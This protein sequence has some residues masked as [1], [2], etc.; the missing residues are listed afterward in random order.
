MSD[1]LPL[2]V[3]RTHYMGIDLGSTFD[4]SAVIVVEGVRHLVPA[5]PTYEEPN[6]HQVAEDHY[7]VRH[8][9][10]SEMGTHYE[11]TVARVAEVSDIY[12]PRF[13]YFDETGV[14]LAVHSLFRQ[15]YIAGRLRPMP[16]G[17]TI[18]G[19]ESIT[20]SGI[21]KKDLLSPVTVLG[22]MGRLHVDENLPGAAKLRQEITD[23]Q[24][25]QNVNT[26][27]VSFGAVTEA[28]H[29]DLVIALAMALVPVLRGVRLGSGAR[30]FQPAN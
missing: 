17:V 28:A 3:G 24:R 26:G 25:R 10:R 23:M 15:F 21:P 6:R 1:D 18:T 29:D 14:G 16:Y 27:H 22:Q 4:R 30:T 5:R 12:R 19:G 7:H 2:H 9:S 8:I 20:D 11:I 13:S